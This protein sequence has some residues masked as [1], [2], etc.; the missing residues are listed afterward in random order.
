M[1]SPRKLIDSK[2]LQQWREA[3]RWVKRGPAPILICLTCNVRG[4]HQSSDCEL[5]LRDVAQIIVN[6]GKFTAAEV[7]RVYYDSYLRAVAL[8]SHEAI[9][10]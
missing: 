8:F 7:S 4:Q 2:A 1:L 9:Y 6:F 5:T 3:Q 10:H